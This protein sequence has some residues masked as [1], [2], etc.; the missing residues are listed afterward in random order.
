MK[1]KYPVICVING[2]PASGKSTVAAALKNYGIANT[3]HISVD[4]IRNLFSKSA[5]FNNAEGEKL[6]FKSTILAVRQAKLYIRQSDNPL[7]IID[8]CIVDLSRLNLYL[9]LL[10]QYMTLTVCLWPNQEVQMKRNRQRESVLISAEHALALRKQM[11]K[12]QI[13]EHHDL[14][15]DNSI[16]TLKQTL[17]PLLSLLKDNL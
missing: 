17:K 3:I 15:V 16:R 2:P 8:D 7:V 14:V 12:S 6:L 1:L 4:D 11:E 5:H 10:G 13:V 9:Q